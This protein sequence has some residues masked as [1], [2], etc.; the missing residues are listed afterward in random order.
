MTAEEIYGRNPVY[1]TLRSGRR[2]LH[3]ITLARGIEIRGRLQEI[4]EMAE[5][6]GLP[7]HDARR[8]E[9][10]RRGVNHQGVLLRAGPYPYSDLAQILDRASASEP[11]FVLLLDEIQDPQNL[12]TLLR[13]AEAFGV[14]GVIIPPHR[15]AGVSPAVVSASSG[16]SEHMLITQTNLVQAMNTLKEH[17]VWITGL[18]AGA[19]AQALAEIELSGGIGLVIGSEGTGMR[20]LVKEACDFLAWIPMRGKVRSLNAAAAGAVAMYEVW[21]ARG[22]AGIDAS[23]ES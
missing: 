4:V 3:R 5:Q 17:E 13:T 15:S 11:S 14:H 12:A 21:A 16:A 10:D 9:L 6:A 7:R 20:R 23:L 18:E 1:E 22:F 8:S 19:K 2:P